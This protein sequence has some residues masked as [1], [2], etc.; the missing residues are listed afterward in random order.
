MLYYTNTPYTV[1]DTY[2]FFSRE[3]KPN[4]CIIQHWA[5]FCSLFNNIIL[6]TMSGTLIVQ[7]GMTVE[8]ATLIT[9]TISTLSHDDVTA[10]YNWN[11]A[12]STHEVISCI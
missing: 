11:D 7:G 2:F 5:W 4:S 9:P 3:V 6:K 10:V 1:T 12:T 8:D